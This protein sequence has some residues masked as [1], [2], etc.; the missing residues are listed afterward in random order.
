MLQIKEARNT[1]RSSYAC[2]LP[3][4][5]H[6]HC[7]VSEGFSCFEW[8]V[9]EGALK[10]WGVVSVWGMMSLVIFDY[11]FLRLMYQVEQS[12]RRRRLAGSWTNH[13]VR[14]VLIVCRQACNIMRWFSFLQSLTLLK[15]TSWGIISHLYL[16]LCLIRS[17]SSLGS[18]GSS[19]A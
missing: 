1:H 2:R 8:Q 14:H 17:K 7:W 16:L 9:S 11:M 4:A 19:S 13:S 18:L 12:W 15:V 10:A 6:K 3:K 5:A